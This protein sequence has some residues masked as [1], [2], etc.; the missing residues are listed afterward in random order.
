MCG[1]WW[2]YIREELVEPGDGSVES[3]EED[4]LLVLGLG[5][6]GEVEEEEVMFGDSFSKAMRE[7]PNR[8]EGQDAAPYSGEAGGDA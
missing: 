6:E 1:Q 8:T 2:F 5:A 4:V 3:G 7:Q